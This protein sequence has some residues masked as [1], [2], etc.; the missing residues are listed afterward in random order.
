M[1]YRYEY[2]LGYFHFFCW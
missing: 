1:V 2:E